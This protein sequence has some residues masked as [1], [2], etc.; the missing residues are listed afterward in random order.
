MGNYFNNN[1]AV[2]LDVVTRG[3]ITL[4][5]VSAMGNGGIGLLLDNQFAGLSSAVSITN[6]LTHGFYGNTT[7]IDIAT[8]GTITLTSVESSGNSVNGA[9]L[10]N[11]SALTLK[12]LTLNYCNFENNGAAGLDATINGA[13]NVYGI[14]A[15]NNT[16][17]GAELTNTGGT[18]LVTYAKRGRSSFIGNGNNGL[19]VTSTG[20]VT[21][22]SAVAESNVLSGVVVTADGNVVVSGTHKSLATSFSRNGAHG[23]NVIGNS[24]ITVNNKVIA[25][26][27]TLAGIHLDNQLA[28][29][30]KKIEVNYSQTNG[31]G[32]RGLWIEGSSTVVLKNIESQGNTQDGVHVDNNAGVSGMVTVSGVNLIAYNGGDGL[33]INTPMAATVSGVT[34]NSNGGS[35]IAIS[36]LGDLTKVSS[37]STNSN[38]N[39]GIEINAADAVQI[40]SVKSLGNGTGV[41]FGDGLWVTTGGGALT[42]QKSLLAANY[43]N[44][45]DSQLGGG[46]LTISNSKNFGNRA[47]NLNN[48]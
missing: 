15:N 35:G 2:G 41:T 6:P 20:A 45:I 39:N 22:Y 5:N 44:G 34:A 32:T 4:T 30:G 11:S 3:A 16:T 19:E 23:V 42:I 31:N 48:H 8:N 27:N 12:T 36:S 18:V 1:G 46:V 28:A 9:T 25:N 24:M 47:V 37:S 29:S 26:G 21:I 10:D 17:K 13:I 40:V 33:V 38:Q 7:G 14:R 43:G